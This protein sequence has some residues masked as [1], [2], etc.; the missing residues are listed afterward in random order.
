M[1]NYWKLP[2]SRP[3]ATHENLSVIIKNYSMFLLV[4]NA[5]VVN[6]DT[7]FDRHRRERGD[8]SA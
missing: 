1:T 3:R 7:A 6:A 4:N 8:R 5:K 2:V